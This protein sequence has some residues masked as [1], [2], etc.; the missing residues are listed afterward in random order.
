M[1][2]TWPRTTRLGDGRTLTELGPNAKS[3]SLWGHA[4]EQALGSSLTSQQWG[5]P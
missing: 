4:L 3:F 5:H 1:I 2:K